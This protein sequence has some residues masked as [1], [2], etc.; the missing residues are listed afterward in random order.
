[1]F[2]AIQGAVGMSTTPS[3]KRGGRQARDFS[4]IM[5]RLGYVIC[6]KKIATLQAHIL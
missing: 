6:E 3:F 4:Y 2:L 5:I 1:M